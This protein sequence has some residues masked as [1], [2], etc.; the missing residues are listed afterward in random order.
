MEENK[1]IENK[2]KIE[3]IEF[4]GMEKND[5]NGFVSGSLTIRLTDLGIDIRGVFAKRERCRYFFDLPYRKVIDST[6]GEVVRFPIFSFHDRE[7]TKA[8]M[9][10]IRELAPEF[11]EKR[12]TDTE[13]PVK[14]S[15]KKQVQPQK[16][17]KQVRKREEDHGKV[18]PK[19]VK[20]DEPKR[21]ETAVVEKAKSTPLNAVKNWQDPPPRKNTFARKDHKEIKFR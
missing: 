10:A 21:L 8:L 19:Q 7:K 12:L 9:G 3:L 11:I 16:P 1:T 14:F 20:D 13:N 2:I 4:Y 15:P 6:T 5:I 17:Q 18:N